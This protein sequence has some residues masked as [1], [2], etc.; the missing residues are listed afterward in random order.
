MI[1]NTKRFGQIEINDGKIITFING[2]MGFENL[3]KYALMD[4]PGTNFLKWLQSVEDP[5]VSLP[6]VNPTVFF[7]DYSPIISQN[8]LEALKIEEPEQAV[9]LCVITVSHD[10]QKATVNLKA[11]II[12]NTDKRLADQVIAENHEYLV[13]QPLNLRKPSQRRCEGC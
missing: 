2:L 8:E 6:V 3:K 10:V 13:R 7:P 5:E 9:V 1:I 12:I 4:H 11:P